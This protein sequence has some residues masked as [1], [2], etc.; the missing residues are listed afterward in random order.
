MVSVLHFVTD[1]DDPQAIINT[2]CAEFLG[3]EAVYVSRD[4]LVLVIDPGLVTA[5]EGGVIRLT[6]AGTRGRR[7]GCR[8]R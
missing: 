1:D 3:Q 8:G 6:P 2:R 7:S 4:Q 5:G